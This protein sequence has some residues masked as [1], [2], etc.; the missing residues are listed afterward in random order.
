M[1]TL[2]ARLNAVA[3]ISLGKRRALG[4][5][6]YS[7]YDGDWPK[8][9]NPSVLTVVLER[10][11]LVLGRL[12]AMCCALLPLRSAYQKDQWVLSRVVR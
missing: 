9:D 1:T 4:S 11:V 2:D 7:K 10:E 5:H 6:Y 8:T 12:W 3:V